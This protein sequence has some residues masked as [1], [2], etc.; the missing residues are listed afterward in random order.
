MVS[1]RNEV[2]AVCIVFISDNIFC[3][4]KRFFCEYVAILRQVIFIR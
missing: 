4:G 3:V 2:I 1:K